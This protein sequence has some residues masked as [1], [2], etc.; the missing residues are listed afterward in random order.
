MVSR[1]E[2]PS[3]TTKLKR[4]A[5]HLFVRRR[6][7][8]R[9]QVETALATNTNSDCMPIA[10]IIFMLVATITAVTGSTSIKVVLSSDCNAT[11]F[12]D[13]SQLR[14]ESCNKS[15]FDA[16][17]SRA[18]DDTSP[19][20]IRSPSPFMC[21]CAPGFFKSPIATDEE[22]SEC[23]QCLS[24][25]VTSM[26]GAR[27]AQCS[28]RD[29]Y[30]PATQTCR[31]L[32]GIIKEVTE[33]GQLVQKCLPCAGYMRRSEVSGSCEP[34]HRSFARNVS[35]QSCEC[36]SNGFKVE[37][38]ICIPNAELLVDANDAHLVKFERKIIRSLFFAKHLQ[39]SAYDC[40]RL[41][42]RTS[43]QLLA[44]LCVLLHLVFTEDPTLEKTSACSEYRKLMMTSGSSFNYQLWPKKAPWLY[45]GADAKSELNRNNIPNRFA[46]GSEVKMVA[47]R[48]NGL[49]HLVDVSK[50]DL[51]EF[52]LCRSARL[53]K[54]LKFGRNVEQDCIISAKHIWDL[55]PESAEDVLFYD[56]YLMSTDGK[57]MYP[58]PVLNLLLE[59]NGER[60]NTKA[61]DEWQLVRRFF[62][63]EGVT[64][65]E[66]KASLEKISNRKT[67][68]RFIQSF[69]LD[70]NL[71]E[72]DG[73]GTIYPPLIT[74]TYGEVNEDDVKS[75]IQVKLSF[76]TSF[77][78][79]QKNVER[80]VSISLSVLCPI[81]VLWSLFQT[82]TWG[83]RCG[84]H[85]VDLLIII[86]FLLI[87]CGT[88]A[89][90]FF[91]VGVACCINW[92]VFFKMQSVL[93]C[94]LPSPDQEY[95]ILVYIT[96]A[97]IMKSFKLA[98]DLTNICTVNIFLIDWERPKFRNLVWPNL[99]K[100]RSVSAKMDDD[101]SK[102]DK[103]DASSQASGQRRGS[104][105]S[106]KSDD[107][108]FSCPD[109][110][111]WRSI[112]VA[113]E[114]LELFT[115]RRLNIELHL[116]LVVFF[117]KFA[118]FEDFVKYDMLRVSDY[119]ASWSFVPDSMA[120]RIAVGALTYTGLA[121]IQIV[122][123]AL[124]YERF[125]RDKMKEYVDLCSV[126]NIS[127]FIWVH[128]RF[129]YYIHG[130][131]ANGRADVNMKEMNE[132]LKR[133]EDDLCS[134]RGLLPNTDQQTFEM[135]LPIAM[136]DH[137]HRIRAASESY[138]QT[139]F[140]NLPGIERHSNRLKVVP[141]YVMVSKF[142]AGFIDH[143]SREFEYTVK[144]KTILES[145]LDAEFDETRE[146]GYFYNGE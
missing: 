141:T 27:C 89:H 88:I 68:V 96:V 71:R 16:R 28:P 128:H 120:C 129:G 56:V 74:I 44:N 126:S 134:K 65:I 33:A 37:A 91:L 9:R 10:M 32:H 72:M 116:F 60:V 137:Y 73:S 41:G 138:Q 39:A 36:P 34:C 122:Y 42:N 53:S 77:S 100:I 31:C 76:Q 83:K 142:L 30:D 94:L 133:E 67:I 17:P 22:S 119:D 25:S 132:L 140:K 15:P 113:N 38:D 48:Y 3:A 124:F 121:L 5:R 144:D 86:Q 105:S 58:V 4:Q 112:L 81:G 115:H 24:N 110:S 1:N 82:W 20:S 139:R 13:E 6:G 97:C 12:Y 64:G 93:H 114:W 45:Y 47:F 26:D 130:R 23:V 2:K 78:R 8:V 108:Q 98:H 14:C 50:L 125:F 79:D 52:Q 51:H 99:P 75:N 101:E 18:G 46:V 135:T 87:S 55:S 131:S 62:L 57:Q 90:I 61:Q 63:A 85:G 49:G 7:G 136:F 92:F 123:K 102:D 111:I 117:L 54:P 19:P 107:R 43:C 103:E 95:L 118:Q 11:E 59:K 145:V 21:T 80:D 35:S 66:E 104:I 40:R 109:V 84:K 146:R 143:T 127:V 69:K 106:K 29:A 70:I